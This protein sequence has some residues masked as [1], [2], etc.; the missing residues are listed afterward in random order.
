M[1]GVDVEEGVVEK[2]KENNPTVNYRKYDGKTLPFENGT[3]DMAFAINVI[4]H[5]SPDDWENFTGEMFRILK[6]GGIAAVFEHNPLNPLTQL[7]VSRCEFD[8][9]ATL[10]HHSRIKKLFNHAGFEILDDAYIVFFP[11]KSK[12]FRA[13]EKFIKWLPLGAQHYAVGRK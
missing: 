7:A 12:F 8:I 2:A 6:P 9:D 11:F 5:V 4:H 3:F 1:Y 10:L 13:A